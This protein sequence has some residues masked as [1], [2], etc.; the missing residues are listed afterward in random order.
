LKAT[1]ELMDGQ[2]VKTAYQSRNGP[3]IQRSAI[4]IL[5]LPDPRDDD[6]NRELD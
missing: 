5:A 3:S 6:H 2:A 4:H 1:K